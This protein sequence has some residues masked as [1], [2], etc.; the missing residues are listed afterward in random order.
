VPVLA[1]AFGDHAATVQDRYPLSAYPS[2][3]VA[4]A[5]EAFHGA[6]GP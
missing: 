5:P 3:A 2:P 1:E 6:E 4:W